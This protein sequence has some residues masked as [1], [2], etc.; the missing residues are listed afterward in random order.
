MYIISFHLHLNLR[1][2]FECETIHGYTKFS[3]MHHIVKE[4][5]FHKLYSIHI[6][7]THTYILICHIDQNCIIASSITHFH[8]QSKNKNKNYRICCYKFLYLLERKPRNE[9]LISLTKT[10]ETNENSRKR[11]PER[12]RNSI[13]LLFSV[14][15][16]RKFKSH[17][18]FETKNF[19]S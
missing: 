8:T 3:L 7:D 9:P 4:P 6:T 19:N 1:S 11:F 13:S 18:N 2:R 14:W 5:L 15:S 16:T 17:E 10:W 12:I